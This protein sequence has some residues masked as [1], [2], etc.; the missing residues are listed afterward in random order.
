MYDTDEKEIEK[1]LESGRYTLSGVAVKPPI[2]KPLVQ[3]GSLSEL[4][5]IVH[6][7][8]HVEISG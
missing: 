6:V 2:L 3:D 8:D 1:E 7:K 4:C 5:E